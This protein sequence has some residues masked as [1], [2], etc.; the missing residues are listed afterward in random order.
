MGSGFRFLIEAGL[1]RGHRDFR[2]IRMHTLPSTRTTA[3]IWNPECSNRKI[4][5]T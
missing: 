5:R 4:F 2:T 3:E 1:G